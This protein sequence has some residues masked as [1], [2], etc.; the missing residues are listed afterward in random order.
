MATDKA[1]NDMFFNCSKDSEIDYVAGNYEDSE[2]VKAFL[3]KKCEDGTISYS[4]HKEVYELIKKELG[5]DVPVN[6]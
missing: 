1:R 3:K 5:Y 2:A 4:R 6:K